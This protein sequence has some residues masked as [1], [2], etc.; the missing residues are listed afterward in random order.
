MSLSKDAKSPKQ[1]EAETGLDEALPA[2]LLGRALN[3]LS[4]DIGHIEGAASSGKLD[5]DTSMTLVRYITAL[6]S[7]QKEHEAT[8]ASTQKSLSKLSMDDLKALARKYSE[9]GTS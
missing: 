6:I 2:A 8:T 5:P 9:E 1:P 3:L 7:L 4:K